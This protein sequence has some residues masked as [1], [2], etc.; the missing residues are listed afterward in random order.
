MSA[1]VGTFRLDGRPAREEGVRAMLHAMPWRSPDGEGVL[2][3]GPVGLGHGMLHTTPESLHEKLPARSAAGTLAIT[4]DARLDNRDE[5]FGALGIEDVSEVADSDLILRAYEHWGE[6]C[7][8]HFLGDF[9]FAIWD[10]REEKLFCARDHFGV[11]PFYYYHKDGELFAFASEIKALHALEDVPARFDEGRIADYLVGLFDDKEVTEFDGIL[12]LPA[13][14]SLTLSRDRFEK[15]RYW[16]LQVG[17]ELTGWTD[18]QYADRF[19]ELLKQAVD[20]RMRAAVPVASELSGG[21]DST[22]VACLARDL[23]KERGEGPMQTVSMVFPESPSDERQ[24]IDQVVREGGLDPTFLDMTEHGPMSTLPEICEHL[25][26]GCWLVGNYY[27]TWHTYKAAAASGAGVLLTGIDGDSTV[28]HGMQILT[29][30]A[31][32]GQWEDFGRE[33][34]LLYGRHRDAKG[35]HDVLATLGTPRE[36]VLRYA[37]PALHRLALGRRHL[38]F[39]KAAGAI[40]RHL[41]ISRTALYRELRRSIVRG[42]RGGDRGEKVAAPAASA[43]AAVREPQCAALMNGGMALTLEG[44][45]HFGALLGVSVIHPYMDVRLVEYMMRLSAHQS[46]AKGWTRIVMRRAMLGIVP[47]E[48]RFRTSKGN[49][50]FHVAR[51]MALA[52]K[53]ALKKALDLPLPGSTTSDT[54]EAHSLFDELHRL[55]G[56]GLWRLAAYAALAFWTNKRYTPASESPAYAKIPQGKDAEEPGRRVSGKASRTVRDDSTSRPECLPFTTLNPRGL[57]EQVHS[58]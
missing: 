34:A 28:G 7:V 13:A 32:T 26:Q 47:D 8:D 45:E 29:H 58:T 1:I 33:A 42:V 43:T 50:T 35:A 30:Y 40:A 27:M 17:E 21:L 52:E 4:A 14:H 44:A 39:Y 53:V 48:I 31:E 3:D 38:A 49:M 23:K 54:E 37:G 18:E 20:C 11:R 57:N 10:A 19:R 22:F 12:R 25:D 6:R 2:C 24:F 55:N 16:T 46:C 41:P 15:K 5:L 51:R 36:I 56:K 9:V